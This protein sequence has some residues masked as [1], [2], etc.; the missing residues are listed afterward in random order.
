M[1]DHARGATHLHTLPDWEEFCDQCA[2]DL[3][4]RDEAAA[5]AL[6]AALRQIGSLELSDDDRTRAHRLLA[7]LSTRITSAPLRYRDGDEA[8]ALSSLYKVFLKTR[9][10]MVKSGGAAQGFS[11]VALIL[12]ER[13]LRPFTGHWH[14]QLE[15]GGLERQDER[16]RFRIELRRL[17]R[18][19]D[20]FRVVL[21]HMAEGSLVSL[22]STLSTSS[23]NADLRRLWPQDFIGP[24]GSAPGPAQLSSELEVVRTRR[25]KAYLEGNPARELG[26]LG[27][28]SADGTGGESVGLVGLALSGGGIRSATFCLG[29]VQVL[30]KYGILRDVDYLSTVSG[31][32]Y[33][34]SFLS[35]RLHWSNRPG[36]DYDALLREV[37]VDS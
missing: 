12:L 5:K 29:V 32:G 17:R 1:G 15:R 37:L 4:Q 31:G 30:A 2:G 35:S 34:G 22:P 20:S 8:A 21:G 28:T 23:T 25:Q 3:N 9:D 27:G 13:V 16:R 24:K 19:L 36:T 6:G 18:Q 10:E 33:L 7:E 14:G 11:N 26:G